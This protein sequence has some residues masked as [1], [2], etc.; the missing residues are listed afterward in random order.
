MRI[1][2]EGEGA[3]KVLILA[4]SVLLDGKYC[5]WSGISTLPSLTGI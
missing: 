1:I 4:L 2:H 3:G 5:A